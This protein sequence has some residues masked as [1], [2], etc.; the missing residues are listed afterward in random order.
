MNSAMS[1]NELI[2]KHT[3]QKHSIRCKCILQQHFDREDPP[4]FH[5]LVLSEIVDGVVKQKIVQCPNCGVLH[6]VIDICESIVMN[7]KE[8]S[9]LL[10]S[11]DDLKLTLP[12]NL[13]SL[14]ELYDLDI[15]SWEQASFIIENEKYGDYIVLSTEVLDDVRYVKYV[16]IL[17]RELY[18]VE[19]F[20]C[21]VT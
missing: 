14:M 13:T 1:E 11:L 8:E 17:G 9:K 15:S 5:F 16:R 4:L 12:K 3:Y 18:K 21:D 19:T 10:T 7:G 2:P 6:K 20:Q